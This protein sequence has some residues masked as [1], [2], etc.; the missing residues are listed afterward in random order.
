MSKNAANRLAL[1]SILAMLT[2][3]G[4]LFVLPSSANAQDISTGLVGHWKLDETSG[5]SIA[6][7]AGTNTGTWSDN[8]GDDVAEETTAGQV[9]TGL[10]FDGVNDIISAGSATSVDNVFV[11][12]GTLSAWIY[13]KSAG[14]ANYGRIFNK[15]SSTGSDNGWA[16]RMD[17][18]QAVR[19]E[20]DCASSNSSWITPASSVSYNQW[21]HIAA[22]FDKDN[23]ANDAT[24]YID[25]IAVSTTNGGS[26]SGSL[27]DD[28]AQTLTIGNYQ[29][30]SRTFDGIIDDARIYDR[31]LT[32]EDVAELASGTAP[33]SLR[34]NDESEGVE[35]H[36]GVEWVHTGTGSYSPNAVHFEDSD[37]DYLNLSTATGPS[38][39]TQWSGS[40]WV[41]RDTLGGTDIIFDSRTGT[42]TLD[43]DLDFG[44][45]DR[46]YIGAK[47][48][49]DTTVLTLNTGALA[50]N[51]WHHVMFSFDLSDA[52]KR[53]V[54]IDD[55]SAINTVT[56]YNTAET[57]DFSGELWTIG[58]YGAGLQ[59]IDGDLADFWMDFGTYID[60]S[61]AA[62]RRKFISAGG[63]PMFLGL[64]G[65]M[66]TGIP[67]DIF[68]SG[69]T[70][71]WHTNKG[72]GGGLTENGALTDAATQPGKI[73]VNPTI[74]N[75]GNAW[76]TNVTKLNGAF[77][78]AIS[79]TYAYVAA[80]NNNSLTVVDIS[81][82]LNPAIANAGAA[83][84]SDATKLNGAIGVAISGSYAYVTSYAGDSL[85][86][87]DISDPL[88]PVIANSGN[89]W[90]TDATKLNGALGV[91][92]SGNYAYVAS[93]NSNS[94]TVVDI[95]DP[96]NPVIANS[97]N[98]WVTDATKLNF[99]TDVTISGNYA[100]VTG[101]A[102]DSLTVVDISDPLNPVI[103]N[104]SA[105]WVTDA[106]KLNSAFG[107]TVSGDYAYVASH[108]GHSLT[109]VDISDPLNPVIANAGAAWVTDATKL[110]GAF[111]VALSGDYAY[112]TSF[113]SD[114]LT[115]VDI[116]DPLNP[117]IANAGNAWVTDATKLNGAHGVALSGR[118]AYVA[119]FASDSL[120]VVDIEE[121]GRC[122]SPVEPKGSILYNTDDKVMQYCNGIDWVAM[123]PVGG[124]GGGGCAS[125][126]GAAGDIIFNEDYS[127]LQYCNA[128]D[129]VAIGRDAD[130][131]SWSNIPVGTACTDGSY[132][133]GLTPDGN[134]PMY[135]AD[136]TTEPSSPDDYWND[137]NTTYS[138][139]SVT[140]TTDGDGNTATLIVTD[141]DSGTG[142]TQP[143]NAAAYCDALSAHGQ[144]DWY[145]PAQDELN[146]LYNIAPIGGLLTDATYYWSST[147]TSASTARAQ[148]FIDGATDTDN[149]NFS[150]VVRCVRK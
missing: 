71:D 146:L 52:A 69:D 57:M 142:G 115:V 127:L 112:V 147:E 37:P 26:C 96:L 131:C 24:I 89:A 67:P 110:N 33:G 45:G 87:V 120:T 70:A 66:I 79:G 136:V 94:L 47:N 31:A 100:Y 56:T 118:Y 77:G 64:D 32:A 14:E 58:S 143:H 21:Y 16:L 65:S 54:Y 55:V 53:H 42:N 61:V 90:V 138:T 149:K 86:V 107:I 85:T 76:V 101:N 72:T 108:A 41:R 1:R 9:G 4:A 103:A 19:L 62:N 102:G 44:G 23:V 5:S 60:L 123:G 13:P 106:T 97:G 141:S 139:T 122:A 121:R 59:P 34:Y 88:N 111:Y 38:S 133:V 8:T 17:S 81:D 116:S 46:I 109:V 51:G 25:G 27:D 22:V 36:D 74:A 144:T 20:H 39:T 128:E 63:V 6:D 3:F 75:A 18:T 129:W 15:A 50:G 2:L 48:S 35:Y 10:D 82:P 135:M 125:P 134:V 140:S 113:S 7:S 12:G 132:Y 40:F 117:A 150:R 28:S 126:V 137:G 83:L 78:I 104:A 148:R 95:S 68:L 84:V 124:T 92:I 99:S 30:T 114:S 91:T 105:A 93:Q 98:A 80:Q 73:F 119:S 11:G 29:A 130:P 145:L 49:A 43:V